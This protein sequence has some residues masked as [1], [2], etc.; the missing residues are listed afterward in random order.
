MSL[1][2]EKKEKKWYR[3]GTNAID[4]KVYK[5]YLNHLYN[6][7]DF[8]I[9]DHPFIEE[10]SK[11][12]SY[13]PFTPEKTLFIKKAMENGENV[14][15]LEI[16]IT[17]VC[18]FKCPGCTFQFSQMDKQLPYEKLENFI[19]ELKEAGYK[20]ITLAGGGEPS[21]Y[22]YQGKRLP[23]VTEK[24]KEHGI[25][26]FVITNSFAL[27]NDADVTRLLLSTKGIRVSIYNFIA[28]GEP[29]TKNET[30]FN[31]IDRM[32]KVK[33]A[34]GVDT[35]ILVANLISWRN[36]KDYQFTLDLAKRFKTIV[37]PRPYIAIQRNAKEAVKGEQLIKILDKVL[38]NYLYIKNEIDPVSS[39][40]AIREFLERVLAF[41]L[42]LVKRCTVTELGLAGKVRANGDIYRCGQISARSYEIEKKYPNINK[43]IFFT[44]L[45][46]K[47]ALNHHMQGVEK[48]T[49]YN[50]CPLCRETI[51]NIR[52]NKFDSIPSNLKLPIMKEIMSCFDDN[53]NLAYF[54]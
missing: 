29:E 42:P 26:T 9:K 15:R 10:M 40:I 13:T 24:F 18:N 28:P 7:E 53:R 43:Q 49:S 12:L 48:L 5:D 25:D 33:E 45:D 19:I 21:I 39:P 22:N 6:L 46:D 50:L 20:A 54:W 30:V 4:P 14:R 32:L 51:N 41:H 17:D 47:S 35:N 11:A 3:E 2:T 36:K 16:D 8:G 52:L 34:L 31:N 44:N 38:E 27:D 23:D 37:T 1:I